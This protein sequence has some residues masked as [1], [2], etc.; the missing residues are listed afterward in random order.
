MKLFKNPQNFIVTRE[1]KLREI[2]VWL[3]LIGNFCLLCKT[4]QIKEDP[5]KILW[6]I[7]SLLPAPFLFHLYEYGQ[8]VKHE[9]A[10]F[11][12]F[13]SVLFVAVVGF[14]SGQIK[15]YYVILVNIIV[16]LLSIFLAMYFIPN[17]GA[18]FT[19]VDRNSWIVI[20]ALFFLVGQLIVRYFSKPSFLK[21]TN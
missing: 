9:E 2:L 16:G 18:W 20:T 3:L 8:H 11:L 7:L 13:G 21:K 5:M 6:L 17:D 15:I 1:K 10:S 14:L 12:L 19:P 4:C